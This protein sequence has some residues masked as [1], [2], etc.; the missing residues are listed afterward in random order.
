MTDQIV[1]PICVKWEPVLALQDESDTTT[2]TTIAYA[3]EEECRVARQVPQ[4]QWSRYGPIIFPVV[5]SVVQT[6]MKTSGADAAAV[7]DAAFERALDA[8]HS[9]H[10]LSTRDLKPARAAWNEQLPAFTKRITVRVQQAR[11]PQ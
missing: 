4:E 9:T 11:S 7:I 10:A 2:R 6:L 8:L 1:D 3:L 5:C